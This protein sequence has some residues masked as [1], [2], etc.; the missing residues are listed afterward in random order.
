MAQGQG[1]GVVLDDATEGKTTIA[2]STSKTRVAA[3]GERGNKRNGDK[4]VRSYS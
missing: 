2:A 4:G 1:H 3:V